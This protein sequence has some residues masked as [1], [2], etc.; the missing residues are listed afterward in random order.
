MNRPVQAPRMM[1]VD[2]G[3]PRRPAAGTGAKA[4]VTPR[5]TAL[6]WRIL[7]I[8]STFSI[9]VAGL[10]ARAITYNI[11]LPA[12]A[13]GA[14][15]LITI[16]LFVAGAAIHTKLLLERTL[17]RD[18][19][20][21]ALEQS[22]ARLR[23]AQ[24]AAGIASVDWDIAD[25]HAVWSSNFVDVFG[26]AGDAGLGKTPYELFIELVHPDDRARIDS[27]HV[28]VLKTGG[29]FSEEFRIRRPDG[30]VRWIATRGEVLCDGEGRPHRLI[31]TNFDITERHRNEDKLKQSL[32]IIEF[33]NDA[34]EIGIWTKNMVVRAGTWDQRARSIFGLLSDSDRINFKVFRRAIHAGD[35][36]QV[37][38]VLIQALKSGEKFALECRIRRPDDTV[39]WIRIR[40]Q[41]DADPRTHR[42][43]TMTGIVFDITERR[44]REAHLR[45]LL[46]ELT[47]RSK[48]LLAVV[49]AMAR[50]T[51]G[52]ATSVEDFQIQFSARLQ[53]IA[54]S[55]DLLVQEDWQ[56]S[57]LTDI[58]HSQVG[59]F[60]DTRG[61][62]VTINGQNLQ[63]KPEAAQHIGLALHE[64]STNASK[65][66][67]LSNADGK[68]SI[69]WS[70]TTIEAGVRRLQIV[71]RES[72]GPPVV[73]PV[74]RGFG[75]R[76]TERI[77]AQA[78]DGKVSLTFQ[79]DGIVWALDIP[80]SY[81]LP[82]SREA[83]AP[84]SK[85]SAHADHTP[86]P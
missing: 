34:G 24:T 37:R 65:F 11:L 50:Q 41:S 54:A 5:I 85:V 31:G 75:S 57:F 56:G 12:A 73:P 38:L 17:Q 60:A 28:G 48:N 23:L 14:T 43:A 64:L 2:T 3:L 33:A 53:S 9:M 22:E 70:F 59:Q 58:V 84:S 51:G 49:Q 83:A 45:V 55:H 39:R 30:E 21:V 67:A 8:A 19:T 27:M 72:G 62:R 29:H 78:L 18:T 10:A 82:N 6:Q 46:R 71:W 32:A 20:R 74:R 25:D 69:S 86:A 36:D 61:G 42:A 16:L 1:K 4:A 81:V 76:V 35:W 52:A 66:G 77:V 7:L 40:G 15:A 68:V 63:L 44:E 13:L 80:A 79:P 26:I 47:H